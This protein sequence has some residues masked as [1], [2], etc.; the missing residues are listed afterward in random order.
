M[1]LEH[2]KEKDRNKKFN[3]NMERLQFPICCRLFKNI[4]K[5]LIT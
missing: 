4:V 3:L 2:R 1:R 5:G